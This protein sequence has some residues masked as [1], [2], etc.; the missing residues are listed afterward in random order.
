MAVKKR[1]AHLR[2]DQAA[3]SALERSFFTFTFFGAMGAVVLV[4]LIVQEALL[5]SVRLARLAQESDVMLTSVVFESGPTV[6]TIGLGILVA[7][8]LAWFFKAF[9]LSSRKRAWF[10]KTTLPTRM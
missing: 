7:A 5:H 2:Y 9:S 10:S 6:R 3:R 8:M 4:T 1:R